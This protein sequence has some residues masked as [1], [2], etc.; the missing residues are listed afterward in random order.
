MLTWQR[1]G[2]GSSGIRWASP[3]LYDRAA[4]AGH[5]HG[6]PGQQIKTQWHTWVA[7]LFRPALAT[8]R[9]TMVYFALSLYAGVEQSSRVES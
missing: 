9:L 6:V 3:V 1:S 5:L 4:F 7:G 2:A 8:A